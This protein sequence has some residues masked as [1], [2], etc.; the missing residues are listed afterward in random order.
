[1]KPLPNSG[2]PVRSSAAP[3]SRS[4]LIIGI[5]GGSGSGKSTVARGVARALAPGSLAFI[6]MD[7]YYLNFSHLPIEQRRMINWDHPDAFDWDLLLNHLGALHDGR[8]VAK[9][10]Y[11]FI[12]HTRSSQTVEIAPAAVVVIDG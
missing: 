5:A 1:M 6:D 9:P 8:S 10:V 11:D 7:A 12:T 4:P 2:P 3:H